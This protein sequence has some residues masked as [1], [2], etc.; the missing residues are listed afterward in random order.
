MSEGVLIS[1]GMCDVDD[2]SDV[3]HYH[4]FF[5]NSFEAKKS[6]HSQDTVEELNQLF[7]KGCDIMGIA[8]PGIVCEY[9]SLLFHL[10]L[11]Y[12]GDDKHPFTFH[13]NIGSYIYGII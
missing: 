13:K 3:S 4:F 1:R 5:L 7:P 12:E 9:S 10:F 11:I 8:T 6:R 2:I